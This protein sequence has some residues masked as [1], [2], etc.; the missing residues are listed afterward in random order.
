MALIDVIEYESAEG[1]LKEIYDD[2]IKKRG[3]LADVHTIQSLNPKTIVSHMDLYLDVMFGTSPLSRPQREMIA[4]IVSIANSCMYCK[5]HHAEAL[6]HYW[7]DQSKID[8]VVADFGTSFLSEPDKLLCGYA[9]QL[10]QSPGR[11]PNEKITSQ[12]KE[13][14]LS[15]R[16][17]LDA[18]L[19]IAYFN[20]VNRMVLGLGVNIE[21][22]QG[23]GYNY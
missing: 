5:K 2:L 17:I 1:R 9:Q 18:T 10:T 12:M 13:S 6:L 22:D 15:D 3:K 23:K 21:K 20:F 7:K 4:V 16:A 11:F 19:V 14:G 8:A